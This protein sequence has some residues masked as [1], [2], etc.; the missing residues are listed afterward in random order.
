VKTHQRIL[1]AARWVVPALSVPTF[2]LAAMAQSPLPD[3]FNPGAN[4][5]VLALA[6]QADGKI[7]LGG[8]F[9][10]LGGQT[11]NYLARLNADGTLD[12]GYDPGANTSVNSLVVQDDGKILV[13][14]SF[15]TLGGQTRNFIGRLN[16]DGTLD[17]LNLVQLKA[18]GEP[19][20]DG[21][22]VAGVV[23]GGSRVQACCRLT[24]IC[25]CCK[26]CSQS[27]KRSRL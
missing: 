6:V 12:A 19:F 22:K 4:S 21:H 8:G 10:T 7:L 2:A 23:P 16:A 13:G 15:A 3:S 17:T 14:G 9:T 24:A 11:R 1:H 27:R 25:A 5:N 26:T 20:G 18:V